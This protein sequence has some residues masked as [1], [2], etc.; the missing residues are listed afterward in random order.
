MEPESVLSW[1]FDGWEDDQ[2]LG[3]GDRA[4]RRWFGG[5]A[6]TDRA[7]VEALGSA[8]D[9]AARGELA[10]WA[11][12]PRS[13]L[14]LVLLLDQVPRNRYRRDP[15]AFATDGLA[16]QVTRRALAAGF[17]RSLS[18]IERSFL[19]LPLMH[20]ESLADH[21]Q[22][23]AAYRALAAESEGHPRAAWFASNLDY[24]LRHRAVIE[25][26]GRYPHRNAE[27]GRDTTPEER[28]HLAGGR[29]F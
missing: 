13:A 8:S 12:A 3:Q 4:T 27:L 1:W 21:D 6:E 26:F 23:L 16:R 22:A 7:I 11:D 5:D 14:A 20:S 19:L 25:R 18:F 28:A 9:E 17:D 10:A 15:R 2:P 24:E 29:P